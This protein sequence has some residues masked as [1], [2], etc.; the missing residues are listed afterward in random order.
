MA[1]YP[2]T[3]DDAKNSHLKIY[4]SQEI[5]NNIQAAFLFRKE[6]GF[7]YFEPEV[8]YKLNDS[9]KLFVQARGTTKKLDT[10]ITGI[11]GSF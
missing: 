11:K 1:Y 8:S 3:A 2:L 10:L 6:K 7:E 5:T 9:T 4:S